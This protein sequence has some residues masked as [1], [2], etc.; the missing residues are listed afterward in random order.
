[1]ND[2]E[3]DAARYRWIK[4]NVTEKLTE[5]SLRC[6]DL[7]FGEHKTQYVLPTL[8]SWADFCGQ[9]TLDEAID[10]KLEAEAALKENKDV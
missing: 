1:M 5:G 6:N 9:I 7:M 10:Y 8:I 4:A 2:I 3:R